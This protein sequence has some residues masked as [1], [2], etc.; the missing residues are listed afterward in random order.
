MNKQELRNIDYT[1]THVARVWE[2]NSNL[3][4]RYQKAGFSIFYNEPRKCTI[5]RIDFADEWSKDFGYKINQLSSD[6]EAIQIARDV[7]K[8]PV[9]DEGLITDFV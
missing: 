9:N 7:F 3:L 1:P 4:D 5:E 6:K 8:L 2:R